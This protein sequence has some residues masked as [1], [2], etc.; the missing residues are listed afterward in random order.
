MSQEHWCERAS[1][2]V[3]LADS[4]KFAGSRWRDAKE[5]L[6]ADDQLAIRFVCLLL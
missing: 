3:V 2:F 5:P 4:C 1:R 6:H